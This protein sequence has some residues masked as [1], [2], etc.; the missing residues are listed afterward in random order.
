MRIAVAGASGMVGRH[1]VGVL[2][3]RGHEVVAISRSAGVDVVTGDGLAAAV[4]GADC[5]IDVTNAGTTDQAAATEFFT[6]VAR[7]LQETGERAGVRRLVVLS[8]LGVD[9]FSGGYFAAKAAQERA[10]LSGPVPVRILRAAQFHE[11]AGQTLEWG[12]QG[13]VSRVPRMRVQP[14]AAEAVAEAL[15]DLATEAEPSA[16]ASGEAPIWEIAGPREEELV[17]MATRL[18]ARRGDPVR[19]EG[20]ENP[21]DP[22][23]EL[24]KAGALLPGPAATLAPESFEDWLSTAV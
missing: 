2:E 11:F 21:A 9:R 18:A 23:R 10:V 17:D 4:A 8:I 19:V 22:D 14:V 20:V 13:E 16:A 6:T 15:A 7:N 1:L 3:A 24:V 12:R 5:V